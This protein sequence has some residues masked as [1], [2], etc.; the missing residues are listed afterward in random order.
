MSR[1]SAFT[2]VSSAKI[3]RRSALPQKRHSGV[4]PKALGAPQQPPESRGFTG[5]AKKPART[6]ACMA[7]PPIRPTPTAAAVLPMANGQ[8]SAPAVMRRAAGSI[9]GEDSQNAITAETGVP[10]ASSAAMNGITSQEQKGVSP[11]TSAASTIIRLSR[12]TKARATSVSAPVA[13]S[14]ATASTAKAMKGRV[15]R[16]APSVKETEGR[17]CAGSSSA[18]AARMAS[19]ASQTRPTFGRSRRLRV[20]ARAAIGAGLYFYISN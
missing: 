8:P 11:P 1:K 16:S 6:A 7:K 19:T 18:T 15:C 3:R 4:P 13:F 20:A 5:S 9:S 17:N 2:F 10:S 14:T 12:P